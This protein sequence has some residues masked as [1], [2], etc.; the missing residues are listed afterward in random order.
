MSKDC[1]QVVFYSTKDTFGGYKT[2][3]VCNTDIKIKIPNELKEPTDKIVQDL[4]YV[5]KAI[6][7]GNSY[8]EKTCLE[9]QH[10][11][12]N[13]I[14]IVPENKFTQDIYLQQVFDIQQDVLEYISKN[15]LEPTIQQLLMDTQLLA[16]EPE[17]VSQFIKITK[18]TLHQVEQF[19]DIVNSTKATLNKQAELFADTELDCYY[20]NDPIEAICPGVILQDLTE[21]EILEAEKY[22]SEAGY[23]DGEQAVQRVFIPAGEFISYVSVKE[24]T[25]LARQ[26][27]LS[28]LNCI[29]E[30][31]P[32]SVD[33]LDEDRPNKQE[34]VTETVK[35]FTDSEWKDWLIETDNLT[36]Q[37]E[38]PVGTVT[39][40]KGMFTSTTSK[41]DANSLATQYAYSLLNCI[42]LNDPTQA[43][44]EDPN[45]RFLNLSP[46][47]T[48]R[49]VTNAPYKGQ[50]IKVKAGYIISELSTADANTQANE[51]AQSLLECCF[52][53][54]FISEQCETY[55]EKDASGIPTGVEIPASYIQDPE[56]SITIV[57]Q[58]GMFTSCTSQEDADSQAR[59]YADSLLEEC[60]YCNQLV[61][62]ECV[63][64][65]VQTAVKEGVTVE[66][67]FID[68]NNITY[69]VGDLYKLALPL[70]HTNIYNPYTG[71]KEDV[72]NWSIDATAGY[73]D[74]AVCVKRNEV[75]ILGSLIPSITPSLKNQ[76]E[77]CQYTNDLVVAGC[78]LEDP[79]KDTAMDDPYIFISKFELPTEENNLCLTAHL[80]SPAPGEY[81][82]IPAGTFTASEYD[83]PRQYKE[84]E[85]EDGSV[86][87]YLY[88]ILPG[89]EGYVY[90]MNID[91]VKS[92]VNEQAVAMA[93]SM[94]ECV[95]SN[96]D[97][98]VICVGTEVKDLCANE[99]NF[100]A[101]NFKQYGDRKLHAMSNTASNPIVI[102]ADTFTSYISKQDV[103]DQTY[104]FGQ[105]LVQCAYGNLPKSCSCKELKKPHTTNHQVYIPEDTFIGPDPNVLDKQAKD[106]AC[107]LVVCYVLKA[108]PQGPPGR[109]GSNGAN[110]RDGKDGTPG[111]C[112][113]PC[114]GVYS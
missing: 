30:S 95:F 39:V 96:P 51:L 79:Y 69:S 9:D 86:V 56:Q 64:P 12:Q 4:E 38:R 7:I 104:L 27:A 107:S 98:T 65:W 50:V 112:D 62:P 41:E 110:G 101:D 78:Q 45:A 59:M 114:H 108:G 16:M 90:G 63:P 10:S 23:S 58:E 60:Y 77:T 80:S 67:Q 6:T 5:V 21:D 71:I 3:Q 20:I 73:P 37:V 92:Y 53:N 81:I 24:A 57:I 75:E 32:I 1:D 93:E 105:S 2:P 46:N 11:G 15:N 70:D 102:P 66:V 74:N 26:A 72:S 91:L 14:V 40:P 85:L 18:L 113:V 29:F 8:L 28:Q 34:G 47:N 100:T 103:L 48:Q 68:K 76:T 82:E 49:H 43:V 36:G 33:C 22:L 55:I 84:K 106:L 17:A 61:L 19:I 89:E 35:T 97:T 44:C 42:Y 94:L 87:Q 13:S 88:P 54:K 109:D 83:L 99:W 111:N 25:D 31:D 52:I